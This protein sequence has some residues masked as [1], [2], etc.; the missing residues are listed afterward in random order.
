M[1]RRRLTLP[2]LEEKLDALSMGGLHRI[3]RRDYERIFGLNSA[4]L[5]RVRNFAKGHA[6]AVSFGDESI[7]FRKKLQARPITVSSSERPS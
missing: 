2:E 7:L 5:G 4:A 1:E 3:T 6:C